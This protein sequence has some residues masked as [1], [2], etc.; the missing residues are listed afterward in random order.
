MAS[1]N[2][3]ALGGNYYGVVRLK[4]SFPIGLGD[5]SGI[6]GGIFAEAGSVWDLGNIGFADDEMFIRASSGVS[7][8]WASPLG[9]LE[10]SYAIPILYEAEDIKQNFS[11]AI[12]TRF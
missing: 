12:S 4:G 6:Y 9:P 7:L 1:P 2:N 10:F 3:D 11:V 8:F 5:D